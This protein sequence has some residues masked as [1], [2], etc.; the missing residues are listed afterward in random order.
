MDAG[1]SYTGLLRLH[2]ET[3]RR[4]LVG[5]SALS[6]SSHQLVPV[7]SFF[8]GMFAE[9]L[10]CAGLCARHRDTAVNPVDEAVALTKLSRKPTDK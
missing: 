1:S 9:H 6:I 10:L 4:R 2:Q 5:A 3:A 7:Y 8:E